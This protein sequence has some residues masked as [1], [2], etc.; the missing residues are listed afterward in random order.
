[1]FIAQF[2]RG[3]AL[4]A[5][6]PN[7][8]GLGLEKAQVPSV[9]RHRRAAVAQAR[10]IEA[11]AVDGK[12]LVDLD[13]RLEGGI[14]VE[15]GDRDEAGVVFGH[16]RG[17]IVHVEAIQGHDEGQLEQQRPAV[18]QAHE[19]RVRGLALGQG[20][21][22]AIGRGACGEGAAFAELV[23][24][25]RGLV[26]NDAARPYPRLDPQVAVD[27]AAQE[28]QDHRAVRQDEAVLVGVAFLARHELALG[29]GGALCFVALGLEKPL[30][31]VKRR[32]LLKIVAAFGLPQRLPRHAQAP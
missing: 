28:N 15:R 4:H 12:G 17:V 21:L 1:M 9:E 5:D 6:C 7:G 8:F 16:A 25:D 20:E 27:Q 32:A 19:R 22:R 13:L 23:G 2:K 11:H 24:I 29:R 14:P 31:D 26:G 3:G 30:R 10:L 18:A